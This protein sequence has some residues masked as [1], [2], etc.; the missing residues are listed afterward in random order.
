VVETPIRGKGAKVMDDKSITGVDPW[1][2]LRFSIIGGLLASPPSRGQ[3]GAALE[4]LAVRR[5]RHPSRA[6]EWITFGASTIE[7]WFYKAVAAADPIAVLARKVRGD[8]GH[9]RVMKPDLLKELDAQYR[10]HRGWSYQLHFDNL[11]ALVEELPDLGPLP[12]YATVRRR[13]LKRGW[14]RRRPL[15]RNPTPGQILAAER[16]EKREV[17]SYE[18][19]TVHGLWHADF[20]EG[21][22]RVLIGSGTYYIPQMYATLD[23]CSRV[24]AHGQ[25]YLSES[26]DTHVHGLGQAILKRGLPYGYMSDKGKAMTALEVEN[27]LARLAVSHATT[28]GYSPYQNAKQEIF[29]TQ[30][31][32]RLMPMLESVDPLTLSFLNRATLA[33]IELEYNRK[34]HSELG[35]PPLDR[36]LQGPDV[37]RPAPTS[38]DLRVAF[39]RQERRTQRRSDGTI[40]IRRVRFEIP[41]RYRTLRHV[42]VRYRSWDLSA[43]YMVDPRTHKVVT[44]LHPQDK[45]RNADGRRRALQPLDEATMAEPAPT[46]GDPLPPLM[47]RLLA[48]YAATGL[49]P[50]YL[51]K[52]EHKEQSDE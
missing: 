35:M 40:S 19:P 39:C 36:M 51:P 29:W 52:D 6:D 27:G 47:R 24:C 9:D 45:A 25:W 7:R 21:R 18:I 13:M 3:L 32:G 20:H 28:L 15:P 43:A 12:S 11:A 31:E 42:W 41:S 33:W 26:A 1:A 38:E 50:A 46:G 14:L 30:V 22:R 23:D 17:R 5:Y 37:S 34:R 44:R 48:K 2:R 16:L 4:Q 8:A 49:P 10:Q